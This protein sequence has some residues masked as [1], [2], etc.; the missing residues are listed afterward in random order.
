MPISSPVSGLLKPLEPA[1]LADAS[2]ITPKVHGQLKSIADTSHGNRRQI[3]LFTGASGTGKTMAA[4]FLA[5]QTGYDIYRIDLAAV[6]SKYIGET[7]KNL[8]MLLGTNSSQEVILMFDEA[9]ALFG[10]R[11]EVRSANG[12][13][14]NRETNHLLQEIEAINGIVILTSNSRNDLDDT[15]L[16]KITTVIDFTQPRA[17]RRISWWA[18]IQGWFRARR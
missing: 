3:L 15:I 10:K 18:R 9:D 16:D 7:E 2:R 11:T 4:R 17:K 6:A 1:G 8:S 14:A 12:R 13:Y 5:G